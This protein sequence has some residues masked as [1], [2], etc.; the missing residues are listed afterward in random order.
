MKNNPGCM[1]HRRAADRTG[2]I[3]AFLVTAGVVAVE[4]SAHADGI[5]RCWG[6]NE[7]GQCYTPANL[8]PCSSVAGG[9]WHTVA[10]RNDGTVRC[11][12]YNNWDQS[13]PP[14]DL[15]PCTSI[16]GGF[17]HTIAIQSMPCTG[18]LNHD[19]QVNGADL[20]VL[21]GQWATSGGTTGADLNLDGTVNGADLGLLLGAWGP[22]TN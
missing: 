3:A 4:Q 20:G 8:G 13:D 17:Y 6:L 12:G 2:L 11:W 9:D 16:A 18:D 7:Y 10:L 21:L 14:L 1:G 22:C 19:T 15:G 5:V